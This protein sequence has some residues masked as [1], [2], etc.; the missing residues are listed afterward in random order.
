MYDGFDAPVGTATERASAQLWP[1]QWVDVNPF[2]TRY[3]LGYHTGADLNLP[4]DR[5]AH[6]S[7]YA[8]ANGTVI[9]AQV[10]PG[11]WGNLIVIQHETSEGAIYSRY[12]H[13]EGIAVKK[14]QAV[15]RGQPICQ[16]GNAFGRWAYHLH[17]DISHHPDRLLRVP[18]DWSASSAAQVKSI[19]TDPKAYIQAH[20]PASLNNT[21]WVI[22][23]AGLNLRAVPAGAILRP[24][25]CG[26]PVETG[27][28]RV[29]GSILWTEAKLATGER[30]W[31]AVREG[32]DL[33][34][35]PVQPKD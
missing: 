21:C 35:S 20:R 24:I 27:A 22:A 3:D 7:V 18:D 16:V 17:F 23:P 25:P 1:G 12:G 6:A 14:G 5:D 34:L 31:L 30:G 9:Y 33:Y 29:T 8:V 19:Y 2:L 4:A 32:N 15:T 10:A 11:T 26:T 28:I 13:V